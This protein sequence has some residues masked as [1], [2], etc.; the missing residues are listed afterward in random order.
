MFPRLSE[1]FILNEILEL[2]RQGMTLHIFSMKRPVEELAHA[3]ASEVRSPITYLPE[4]FLQ[5]PL[6]ILRGQVYAWRNHRSA[7]RHTLRNVLRRVR[8]GSNRSDLLA[9]CQ[10]CSVIRDMRGIRHL[11]AHYAS[12]PARLAL[13]VRRISGASY[14]ITTHAKDIFQDNPFASPKLLERMLQANFV[15]AN[16]RFSAEHIRLGLGAP[17]EIHTIYNGIDLDAFPLRKSKPDEPVIL[18]VGRLVEKKGFSDLIYACQILKQRGAKFTCELVGTGRLSKDLK[19][20]I[21]NCGVGDR[22]RMVGPL[23]QQV[24]REHLER[25]T[26]FALPCIQAQDGDRDILPNVIKE[27]MAVGVPA[28][29]TRLD[30]IEELIEN[31][32]SGALVPPGNPSALAAKLELLL[33]DQ[34]IRRRLALGGR[35]MIEERFDRRSNIVKLKSLLQS[36]ADGRATETL[37]SPAIELETQHANCLR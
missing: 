4:S 28:V 32:V 1:T 19:E 15:V 10:A 33:N 3:H 14:S 35:T 25:A 37:A 16:S 20:Q 24:L 2:E 36:A 6:S 23:P 27:A 11:H 26:V 17:A 12:V 18:S 5:S 13:L 34:H 22:I 21:R 9:L 30:G 29:T 8:A 7:W 31:G